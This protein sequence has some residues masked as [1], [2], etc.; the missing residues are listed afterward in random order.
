[1]EPLVKKFTWG[2]FIVAG[3]LCDLSGVEHGLII[4]E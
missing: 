4:I 3:F 1:M 2:F